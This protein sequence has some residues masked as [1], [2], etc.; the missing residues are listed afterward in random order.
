RRA[1]RM[2]GVRPAPAASTTPPSTAPKLANPTRRGVAGASSSPP[3]QSGGL[4][5]TG[6][7]RARR[8]RG[9][10]V[11]SGTAATRYGR[12]IYVVGGSVNVA[13]GGY[14]ILLCTIAK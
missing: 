12:E 1:P 11:S 13:R 4:P 2:D 7:P 10:A 3:R 6:T 9:G 5:C 8:E 14:S